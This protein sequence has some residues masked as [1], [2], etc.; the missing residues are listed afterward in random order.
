[1]YSSGDILPCL[2]LCLVVDAGDVGVAACLRRDKGGLGDEQGSGVG[3]S[4]GVIFGD[5]GKRDVG[6][7]GAVPG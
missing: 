3:S 5:E 2:D 4:L 1:M 6:G 7:I